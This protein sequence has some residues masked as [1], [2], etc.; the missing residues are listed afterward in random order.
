[1]RESNEEE[2]LDESV[3]DESLERSPALS[4]RPFAS[5]NSGEFLRESIDDETYSEEFHE[6]TMSR[7]ASPRAPGPIDRTSRHAA[8]AHRNDTHRSHS[9]E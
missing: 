4:G 9:D 8:F 2:P 6:G 3:A 1:M 5:D 7:T